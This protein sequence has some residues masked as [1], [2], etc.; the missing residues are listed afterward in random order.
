MFTDKEIAKAFLSDMTRKRMVGASVA[1]DVFDA[2]G[3]GDWAEVCFNYV[4]S[5]NLDDRS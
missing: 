1:N 4:P 3:N 2:D 5:V